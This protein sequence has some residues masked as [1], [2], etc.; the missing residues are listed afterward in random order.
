MIIKETIFSSLY[1]Y[2]LP[3]D[4]CFFGV[5]VVVDFHDYQF[6]LVSLTEALLHYWIHIRSYD[7]ASDLGKILFF[8]V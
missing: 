2:L 4:I 8:Y 6:I 5:F 3:T 7:L 1:N